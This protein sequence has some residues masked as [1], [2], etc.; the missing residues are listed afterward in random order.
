LPELGDWLVSRVILPSEWR[1]Q[2]WKNG[3]GVTRE[4]VRWPDVD[5]YDV[6]VSVAEV[7]QPGPFSRFAG[8]RRWSVLLEPARI[9]LSTGEATAWLT[10]VGDV[11]E[12]DGDVAITSRLPDGPTCLLN[13]IGRPGTRVGVGAS[14]T[15]VRFVF[16][17]AAHK[18]LARW[19]AR[20]LDPPRGVAAGP[21]VWIA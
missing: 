12:L 8:H 5:D 11:L 1:A 20:V 21:I 15:P 13:I 4:V 19:H 3:G 14:S 18:D 10:D 7:A 6:R 17:V 2:P 9:G 16:A